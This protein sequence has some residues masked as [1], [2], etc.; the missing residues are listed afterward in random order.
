MFDVAVV[1]AGPSGTIA[2]KICASNKLKTLL[3]EKKPLPRD[4]PCGGY[5]SPSALPIIQ[6]NFGKIPQNLVESRPNDIILLPKCDLHQPISGVSVYRKT[7]DYW[8]TQKSEEA[9]AVIDNTAL[10]SL[11]RKHNY[12]VIELKHNNLNKKISAKYIV[13]ADGVGS[14]V[15]S[16]LYPNHKRQMARTYQAYVEGLLPKEA[17]YI[18]FPLKEPRVTFFWAIPKK[19]VVV[20][21]VGGLPPINLKKLM[22]N[23]LSMVKKICGLGRVLKYETYPIPM[24]SPSNFKLGE[25]RILI[26]GDAASLANPFTG[27]G[28]HSSLMSGKLASEA[29]I[30]NFNEPSQVFRTYKKQMRP[31][32]TRLREMHTLFTY[33][34]S[35]DYVRRKSF[36]ED[37]LEP[38][39]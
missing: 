14:A 22:Q 27:E 1:G 18:Y 26:V 28:I 3:I 10:R 20:V 39:I 7:F 21:G 16:F 5:L 19:N 36:L 13:G 11:S 25:K 32:L 6:E 33:Y 12:I 2:A 37:S 35:L 17:V 29:I 15:R 4:K 9:G 30:K 23:F 8:L 31:L 34:Q 38:Y 24:F